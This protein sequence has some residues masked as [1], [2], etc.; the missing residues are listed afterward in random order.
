MHC[1]INQLLKKL[2][3]IVGKEITEHIVREQLIDDGYPRNI[4]L[5]DINYEIRVTNRIDAYLKVAT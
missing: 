5:K 1:L 2:N 4:D 3:E